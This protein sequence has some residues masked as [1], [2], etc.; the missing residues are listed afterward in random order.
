MIQKNNVQDLSLKCYG[1]F[2]K[3]QHQL[4]CYIFLAANLSY[5]LVNIK[6]SPTNKGM[7]KPVLSVTFFIL[8]FFINIFVI[9]N[10]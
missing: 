9:N 6:N 8:N 4:Y 2:V 1:K 10:F 3:T 5:E 7:I